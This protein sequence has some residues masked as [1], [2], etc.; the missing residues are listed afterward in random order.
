MRLNLSNTALGRY[1]KDNR[2]SN[3]VHNP[4]YQEAAQQG[5]SD[6]ERDTIHI[7]NLPWQL[8]RHDLVLEATG[9]VAGQ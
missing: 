6:C 2:P 5:E 8:V 7:D 9:C 4:L 1:L 3:D